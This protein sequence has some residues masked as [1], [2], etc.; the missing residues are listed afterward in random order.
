MAQ[1]INIKL[2]VDTG[3]AN[4][5][6]GQLKN[7]IQG[8]GE[9]ADK[10]T[11]S[12]SKMSGSLNQT[13]KSIKS[14]GL[15]DA[16]R[17]IER[18]GSGFTNLKLSNVTSGFR[19]LGAA[20]AANPIGAIVTAVLALVSAF[21][22]LQVILDFILAPIK[23][24]F[25]AFRSGGDDID[26]ATQRMNEFN[27]KMTESQFQYD[28]TIVA[29]ERKLNLMKEEGATAAALAEQERLIAVEK[30]KFLWKQQEELEKQINATNVILEAGA[31]DGRKLTEKQIEEQNKNLLKFNTELKK[32]ELE[33]EKNYGALNVLEVK[34]KN[35]EKT[36][37]DK[38][39]VV[40]TKAEALKE[41]KNLQEAEM[42]KIVVTEE[43]STARWMA[44]KN[45]IDRVEEFRIKRAKDLEITEN[46]I[47]IIKANNIEKRKK[48]DEEYYKYNSNLKTI[49]I[50]ELKLKT[51]DE[52]RLN[53]MAS[54]AILQI[55]NTTYQS[56][57]DKR[58]EE[59]RGLAEVASEAQ[60]YAQMGAE[61]VNGIADL[62]FSHKKRNLEKGS[63]EE[64][65][66]AKKQF[67]FGKAVQ[68]SL[69]VVDGFKAITTSL[70]NSPIAFG[71][72]PNPAGIASLAF[73]AAT[74]AINIAKIASM[75]FQATPSAPPDGGTTTPNISTTS[76][77]QAP[78]FTPTQFF[79]LGQTTP[80]LNE[81]SGPTRVYVTEGDISNT[82]NRVRV[83][84][85]RARFG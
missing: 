58:R 37:S 26:Y 50:E 57:A 55:D 66:V 53:K 51:N 81:Q 46:G 56:K 79:G 18:L 64:Q 6:V 3:G 12:T 59:I 52:A 2:N 67:E 80:G 45:Y 11:Q 25:G 39:Y 15:E 54:D 33:L 47:T 34:K 84:E 71:A 44:E 30:S 49:D 4:Q 38:Q 22:G 74:T 13:S 5:T 42:A 1:E 10:T 68:L 43:G 28:K 69:A 82:Q 29:M 27:Q 72:V 36:K 83:V 21:G 7:D 24:L 70:A 62:V 23:N 61:V 73:A 19:M 16:S 35:A 17:G 31:I 8:V 65:K 78:T 48:L 77:V 40:N 85:N 14:L 60:K 9:A 41:L 20:I 32:V 76:P 75:K 63:E